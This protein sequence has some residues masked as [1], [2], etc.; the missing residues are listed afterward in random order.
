MPTPALSA[1]RI[2][3]W[4]WA[5]RFFK[6]RSLATNAVELGRVLQNEDRIKPAH[7]VKVGDLLEI[8][9]AEQVWTIEVIR[10]LEV[11][12]AASIAQTMYTETAESIAKRQQ[13]AEH[14][15]LHTEPAAQLQQRP[16]K[17]QR[18]QLINV[19]ID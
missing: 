18:R 1:T 3:K 11:R 4:L 6:T 16:T 15:R 13:R 10:I 17:R 9:H 19:Q 5:A 8:H 2:D 12:G 14:R 7:A